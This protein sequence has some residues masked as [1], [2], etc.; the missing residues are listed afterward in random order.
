MD[1]VASLLS[2]HLT[3]GLVTAAATFIVALSVWPKSKADKSSG[4]RKGCWFL[5]YFFVLIIGCACTYFAFEM[6]RMEKD[7]IKKDDEK[8]YRVLYDKQQR[9]LAELYAAR[10]QDAVDIS[11]SQRRAR[12]PFIDQWT[13]NIS[14]CSTNNFEERDK[15]ITEQTAKSRLL[16]EFRLTEETYGVLAFVYTFIQDSAHAVSDKEGLNIKIDPTPLPTNFY[17]RAEESLEDKAY[18]TDDVI[19]KRAIVFTNGSSWTLYLVAPRPPSDER[20]PYVSIDFRSIKNPPFNYNVFVYPNKEKI[21]I[22]Y[23]VQIPEHEANT[24]T[25]FGYEDF[26]TTLTTNLAKVLET[27]FK[28]IN[29]KWRFVY[30]DSK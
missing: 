6:S 9:T 3:P 19:N 30:P 15:K 27:Q 18:A 10:H 21:K 17:E 16:D 20:P 25:E 5:V 2:E 29:R 23:V 12:K 14:E 22:Q 7:R 1:N 13:D 28:L 8:R 26:E 4:F 24:T 11:E